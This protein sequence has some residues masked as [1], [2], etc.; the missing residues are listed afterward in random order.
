MTNYEKI[1]VMAGAFKTA[2]VATMVLNSDNIIIAVNSAAANVLGYPTSAL[3][4]RSLGEIVATTQDH[5]HSAPM[6]KYL[7][8][9]KQMDAHDSVE[10][11]NGRK[12]RVLRQVLIIGEARYFVGEIS[13]A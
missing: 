7:D 3:E 1:A 5:P 4:G 10:L 9:R 8:G 11:A 12:V 13:S 6:E 2:S